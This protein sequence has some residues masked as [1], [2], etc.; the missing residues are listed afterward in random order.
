MYGTHCLFVSLSCFC[1]FLPHAQNLFSPIELS[2]HWAFFSLQIAF[3][4]LQCILL[5]SYK[6]NKEVHSESVVSQTGQTPLPKEFSYKMP[7]S[8]FLTRALLLLFP[9]GSPHFH[10]GEAV[11]AGDVRGLHVAP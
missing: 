2:T 1:G 8:V 6:S 3:L 11:T 10:S 9:G 5:T 4:E 7:V